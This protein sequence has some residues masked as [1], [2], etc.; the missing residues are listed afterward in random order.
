MPAH[1]STPTNQP[2]S[3]PPVAGA[4][5]LIAAPFTPLRPDGSIHLDLIPT[6]ANTL[7]KN[8]VSGVFING[9]TGEGL[10]HSR[11]DRIALAEAWRAASRSKLHLIVHVGHSSIEESKMLARHAES[12]QADGIASIG[13]VFF[14]PS[15]PAAWVSAC[16]EMA[17]AAPQIAFYYYHMP[18]MS[19]VRFKASDV[20]PALAQS[21]PNFRGIKFT[22]EDLEDYQRCLELA[23]GRYEVFFGRDELLLTGL[24]L[25][26]TSA[27]GSTYNFAAPLYLRLAEW[28]HL[29]R[30]DEAAS[31]QNLCSEAI[32]LMIRNGGL[33]SIRAT[34]G[35]FGVDCGPMR[36]PL[37]APAPERIQKLAAELESLG[38]FHQ[39]QLAQA[40]RQ[41]AA[42]V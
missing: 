10:S 20:L 17:A 40:S 35:L 41:L 5:K 8:G 30:T 33:P 34:M 22:H 26:A 3:I 25:G 36:L 9:T 6:Y 23:N 27:V 31:L 21:I 14:E 39:L 1:F 12:I 4:V 2:S 7:A 32:N 28:Q 11:E 42:T 38:Y 16:Q 24:K 18:S 13:A 15:S 19:R 37:Q 29:G